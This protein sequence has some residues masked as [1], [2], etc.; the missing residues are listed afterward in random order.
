MKLSHHPKLWMQVREE[1]NIVNIT[2]ELMMLCT[3]EN[4]MDNNKYLLFLFWDILCEGPLVQEGL[5]LLVNYPFDALDISL[6]SQTVDVRKA[7]KKMALKYR[8]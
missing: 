4:F 1:N 3:C 2:I 7:Y 5:T 6:E 8:E